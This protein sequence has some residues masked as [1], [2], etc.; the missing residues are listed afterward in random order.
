M[1]NTI[2][3]SQRRSE[4]RCIFL[5]TITVKRDNVQQQNAD[6]IKIIVI[7]GI[8][9]I[10]VYYPYIIINMANMSY[11]AQIR[12]GFH[13]A[14][15]LVKICDR[16]CLSNKHLYY[17]S[18]LRCHVICLPSTQLSTSLIFQSSISHVSSII[19]MDVFTIP[20]PHIDFNR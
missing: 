12:F 18:R 1:T 4:D 5:S 6:K 7:D 3:L 15:V 13:T 2:L 10:H 11:A 20:C 14:L 19:P 16:C 17:V 9:F 8:Q